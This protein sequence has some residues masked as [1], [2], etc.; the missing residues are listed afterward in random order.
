MLCACLERD[1]FLKLR[2]L[3]AEIFWWSETFS[4]PEEQVNC[5]EGFSKDA[6]MER[7]H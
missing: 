4:Q 5:S 6:R 2:L 1:G 3:V 7:F